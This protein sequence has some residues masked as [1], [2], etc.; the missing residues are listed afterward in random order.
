MILMSN[1]V[2]QTLLL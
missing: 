2:Q 1:D